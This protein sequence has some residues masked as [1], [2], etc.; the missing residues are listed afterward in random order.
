MPARKLPAK[1]PFSNLPPQQPMNP[2]ADAYGQTAILLSQLAAIETRCA[3]DLPYGPAPAQRLDIYMP[4]DRSLKDLPV[5]INIHGGGWMFGYKE[6][7][8]VNAPPIVTGSAIYV[9]IEYTLSPAARFPTQID[10]CVAALAWVYRN[11]VRYGGSPDRIHVGGHSAG[12]HLCALMALRRDLLTKA[13]LPADVIKACFPY[14]GVYDL[15]D[16]VAYGFDNDIHGGPRQALLAD[17]ADA[18]GASPIAWIEGN[19]TPFLIA[20]SEFDNMLCKAEGPSFAV[21]LREQGGRVEAYQA[22]RFDHFW[23]HLDQGWEGSKWT[24]T[25]LSWMHGDPKTAPVLEAL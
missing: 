7:M 19:D 3:L 17:P 6:W 21:A 23:I 13:G 16:L 1:L 4:D 25:L 24:R 20:W 22:P 9:A 5:F 12:G 15:R 14:S 18:R 2:R 11:I 8:G 10:D